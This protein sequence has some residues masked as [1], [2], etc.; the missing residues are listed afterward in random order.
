MPSLRGTA[1]FDASAERTIPAR[2]IAKEKMTKTKHIRTNPYETVERLVALKSL[3]AGG[4]RTRAEILDALPEYQEDPQFQKLRRDF[5][6]LEALGYRVGHERLDKLHWLIPPPPEVDWSEEELQ[7]LAMIREVFRKGIHGAEEVKKV[8]TRLEKGMRPEQERVYHRKPPTGM[9]LQAMPHDET[10]PAI[11]RRLEKAL[12]KQRV[13]FEYH[14]P[15]K[16]V[17]VCHRDLQPCALEFRDGHYYL[18]GYSLE[19]N[20]YLE[21]RVDRITGRTLQVLPSRASPPP[22]HPMVAVRVR[23]SAKLARSGTIPRFQ[24]AAL[25]PQADGTLLINGQDFTEFRIIQT[26]LRYGEH[27]EILSPAGLR[28]KMRRVVEEMGTVY[29]Q[30]I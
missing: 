6:A 1:W 22:S 19:R 18:W 16:D 5:K 21:F 30:N 24:E 7:A 23:L 13:R 4:G 10:S 12:N 14:P 29:E 11:L 27:A 26:L 17:T 8:L 15:N 3:L 25:V 20:R 9:S 2:W 28:E